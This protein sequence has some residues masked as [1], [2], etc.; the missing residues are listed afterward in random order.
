M[1]R[2]GP[3]A[4]ARLAAI[5]VGSNS[6]RLLI[7]QYDPVTGLAPIDEIKAQPRLA[8]GLAA[9][10]ALAPEAMDRALEALR[11][12]AD[13]CTRRG[14][15]QV[16]AVATAAVREAKNGAAFVRRVREE[17]DLPLQVISTE[18]EAQLSY[19]SVRHHFRLDD[20][21]A[22]I[23]DIG[24]GSLEL[25]GAVNGL[26]ELSRSL[27]YG[28]VRLTEQHLPGRRAAHRE[29]AALRKQLDKRLT[30]QLPKRAWTG[31]RIIGSGGTFTNLGRMAVARRG[32][33][34]TEPVHGIDVSVAELE[35]LLEWLA[36]RSAAQRRD[37][38]GLNPERADIILAGLAVVASL[39]R[40]LDAGG[41]T[42][43]A[44]GLR[45]GLLWEMVGAGAAATPPV[46]PMRLVRE[47]ADRCRT[48]RR[49]VEQVRLLAL[50]LFDQIGEAIGCTA[51]ERHILEAASLLHDVG[52]L[53]SYKSHHRHSY[54]LIMHADRIGLGARDRALVALVS[55]YHRRRGP[56]KSDAPFAALAADDQALV[57]R[58]AGLLRVADGL[59]RGH[60]AVVDQVTAELTRKKLVLRIA[61][62]RAG[63]NMELECWAAR[64]KSDVLQKIV[65]KKL[66]I[67]ASLAPAG[68][69]GA[70]A[71]KRASRRTAPRRS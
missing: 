69:Q 10:G 67:T 68:R 14:A 53:V 25:V 52:Q 9:T 44:Y 57:R 37:V 27:P 7:A 66:T 56:K 35:H 59:D 22:L 46:D 11:R 62:R 26:V 49:H 13:V 4:P 42:V 21:K 19:L 17:L 16:A 31:A 15:T 65:G 34:P 20:T 70:K 38:P 51:A 33:D 45:E 18:R 58:V 8:Q 36:T 40:R 29:V 2:P 47:F 50:S 5:D 28:A 54:Q 3:G 43:S 41:V 30:R 64:R 60:T 12:M 6:I 39:L 55:R 32:G 48:D 24:G 1:T 61:P 23:A 63:A 71:P